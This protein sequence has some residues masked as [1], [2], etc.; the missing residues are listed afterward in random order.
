MALPTSLPEV[1]HPTQETHTD[2]WG[3]HTPM[4]NTMCKSAAGA[5]ALIRLC[6]FVPLCL[7][8]I[9]ATVRSKD[10]VSI[11]LLVTKL[12]SILQAY[13]ACIKFILLY[14]FLLE[15]LKWTLLQNSCK[16]TA[17]QLD[18]HGSC[19]VCRL[20]SWPHNY[21][22]G[23]TPW[24]APTWWDCSTSCSTSILFDSMKQ[25]TQWPGNKSFRGGWPLS[26]DH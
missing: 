10:N 23:S 15:S 19:T 12:R 13:F 6:H 11:R 18:A 3:S 5:K 14:F 20:L 1:L 21:L 2:P 17:I 22:E 26:S 25:T 4:D 16:P 24:T 8:T 9:W 7:P